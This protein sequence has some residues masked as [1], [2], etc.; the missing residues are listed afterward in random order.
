LGAD[1]DGLV[2]EVLLDKANGLSGKTVIHPTHV[3]IVHA[4][5][6]V[7]HEEWE[8]AAAVCGGAGSHASP[9]RNKMNESRPHASWARLVLLRARAFGVLAERVTFAE[10]LAATM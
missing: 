2:R 4:L 5:L 10:L 8:D 1:L 9:Y 6:A 3:A 7:T